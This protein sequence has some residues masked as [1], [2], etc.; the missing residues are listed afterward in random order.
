[1]A[2]T[3]KQTEPDPKPASEQN[4]I[5]WRSLLASSACAVVVIIT[6][7]LGWREPLA[8]DHLAPAEV[9]I[10]EAH[11]YQL[12]GLREFTV[13]GEYPA[14]SAQTSKD[15]LTVHPT[16]PGVYVVT[17]VTAESVAQSVLTCRDP[18]EPEV[19]DDGTVPNPD[20]DSF[21]RRLRDLFLTTVPEEFRYCADQIADN[22]D[23]VARVGYAQ[24]SQVEQALKSLNRGTLGFDAA[25]TDS[26]LE[27]AWQKFLGAGG[28][29]SVF[30]EEEYPSGNIQWHEVLPAIAEAIRP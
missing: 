19:P 1:M 16:Q 20:R 27:A 22:Y 9:R 17:L 11:Y 13:L 21:I 8:I 10:G 2:K 7:I 12:E 24:T 6:I 25:G 3:K 23:T 30:L 26:G 15:V 28:A 18:N 5:D 14:I 4:S 29:L